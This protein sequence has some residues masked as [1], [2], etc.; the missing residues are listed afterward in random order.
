M[1]RKTLI[2]V[3][4]PLLYFYAHELQHRKIQLYR[5]KNNGQSIKLQKKKSSHP[6]FFKYT[7]NYIYFFKTHNHLG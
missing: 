1:E 7:I 2:F 3:C 4:F 6:Y 5:N